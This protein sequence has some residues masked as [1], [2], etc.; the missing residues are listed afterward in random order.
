MIEE[1]TMKNAANVVQLP[2]YGSNA[3]EVEFDKNVVPEA[4]G[5]SAGEREILRQAEQIYLKLAMRP[6]ALISDY[7]DAANF[8]KARLAHLPHEEFHVLHLDNRHCVLEI[9]SMCR[10]TVDEVHVHIREIVRDC[11][12]HN[13][14]A[15]LLAHNHPSG[16]NDPSAHDKRITKNIIKAMSLIGVRVLDHLI[17]GH[18]EPFSMKAH[19]LL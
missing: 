2:L 15:I 11:M 8:L 7:G 17:I 6:G 12:R 4:P 10:G 19:D 16:K 14:V 3:T 5:L 1:M 13:S 18:E 9:E